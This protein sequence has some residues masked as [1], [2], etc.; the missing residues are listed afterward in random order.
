MTGVTL[1]T[2]EGVRIPIERI[3]ASPRI[4]P[5]LLGRRGVDFDASLYEGHVRGVAEQG[6]GTQRVAAK[7]TGIDLARAASI[8]KATGLDLG[9][10]LGGEW[11]VT[12]DT[13]DP[14]KSSGRIDLSLENAAV[15]GGQVPVPSMGGSM[16]VPKIAIGTVAA[17]AT[18]RDGKAVFETLQSKSEDLEVKADGLYFVVQARLAYAPIFGSATVKLRDAFWTRSGTAGFKGV[19]DMALA[20]AR[21]RDGAYAF[22][23][24]GTAS[25]PQVRLGP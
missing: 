7:L 20:Q 6:R 5:L 9:G 14:T 19:V 3:Q 16:A 12:I 10:V 1:E 25:Q 13:R 15:N 8:R 11:D 23:I 21:G 17:K 22:Q 2:R 24:F 4:L 18:V